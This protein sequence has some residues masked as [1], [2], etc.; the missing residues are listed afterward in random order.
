[1]D[2]KGKR[3]ACLQTQG[4][5]AQSRGLECKS[6]VPVKIPSLKMRPAQG[7]KMAK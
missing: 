5:D 7:L 3:A 2:L 1:M 4:N 6:K